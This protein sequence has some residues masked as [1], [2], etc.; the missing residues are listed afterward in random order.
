MCLLGNLN[1][2]LTLWCWNGFVNLPT[3]QIQTPSFLKVNQNESEKIETQI[4]EKNNMGI[5]NLKMI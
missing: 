2:P 5:R 4:S 3:S 1:R